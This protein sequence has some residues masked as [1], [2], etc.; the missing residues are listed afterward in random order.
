MCAEAN[1]K[2]AYENTMTGF[3]FVFERRQ[4]QEN[5]H[6]MSMTEKTVYDLLKGK[7]YLTIKE[8]ALITF[9]SEKTISRAIKGLK[10]KGFIVREGTD[11]DGYWTILKESNTI[12]FRLR[13]SKGERFS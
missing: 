4:G 13:S 6:D 10:E 3:R 11:N 1:V 5:V 2:Y 12:G 8:M 7:D 9:K